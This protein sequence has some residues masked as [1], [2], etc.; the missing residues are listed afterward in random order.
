MANTNNSRSQNS[1]NSQLLPI[2]T[3]FR[4]ATGQYSFGLLGYDNITE[5]EIPSPIGILK[6][7]KKNSRKPPTVFLIFRNPVQKALHELHFRYERNEVSKIS[8]SLW[9]WVKMNDPVLKNI[10]TDLYNK[11]SMEWRRGRL[12]IEFFTPLAPDSCNNDNNKKSDNNIDES[13]IKNAGEVIVAP[14]PAAKV[15][16]CKLTMSEEREIMKDLFSELV[17]YI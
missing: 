13:Q 12:I 9:K 1:Q 16:V 7:C 14:A 10:F 3:L 15:L 17:Y 6:T 8:S 2:A 4:I 5:F 11:T